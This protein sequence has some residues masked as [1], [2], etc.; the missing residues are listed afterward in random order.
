MLN[1]KIQQKILQKFHP[2]SKIRKF[3]K[4]LFKVK[5]FLFELK[6]KGL[7]FVFELRNF[8]TKNK[9]ISANFEGILFK[10]HPK[11]GIVFG[12]WKNGEYEKE[13]L[14]FLLSQMKP[15]TVFF[16]IGAN[17]GI[18]SILAGLK[19]KNAQ[20]YAFEPASET[21]EILNENIKLN[22]LKN[23]KTLRL[24]IGSR[25][26][27][28]TLK[29]NKKWRDGLNTMGDPSHPGCQ[30]VGE[31]KVSVTTLDNFLETNNISRVDIMKVDVEGAELL[32]FRGGKELL[33]KD[34]PLIIYESSFNTK[35][36]NYHPVEMIWFLRKIS[37]SLYRVDE[38]AGK[39][40]PYNPG[41]GYE[42]NLIATKNPLYFL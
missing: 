33:Q 4:L 31:E 7:I 37:Y 17:I 28:T 18:F 22:S 38:Q 13:N 41:N 12:I 16:D 24:A 15:R 23:V 34:S 19:E 32:V 39:V 40:M 35:G 27:E 20:I 9:P 10:L 26:G 25:V 29:I 21:F 30:V 8:L 1:E 42:G 3:L 5:N 14:K 6:E 36:F 2:H 11:R